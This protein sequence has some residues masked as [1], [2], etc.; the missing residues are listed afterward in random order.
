MISATSSSSFLGCGS[1]LVIGPSTDDTSSILATLQRDGF[2]VRHVIGVDE[3]MAALRG[4]WL[5]ALVVLADGAD[6]STLAVCRLVRH[7]P[8]LSRMPIVVIGASVPTN[9]MIRVLRAGADLYATV[10]DDRDLLLA[11][12]KTILR[13]CAWAEAEADVDFDRQDR[14]IRVGDLMIRPARYAAHVNGQPIDL[15]VSEFRVLL[16]LASRSGRVFTRE[17]VFASLHQHDGDVSD[18]SIDSHVYTLRRKLGASSAVIETVRGVGY[19]LIA[20]AL[21]TDEE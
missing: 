12:I 5:D 6:P 4:E 3:A 17:Q 16:L 15:T 21:A 1:V 7:D 19:R 9:E 11:R 13:R 2:G 8:E 10:Q 20:K 14:V 18:R